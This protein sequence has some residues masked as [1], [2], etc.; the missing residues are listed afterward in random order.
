VS[1]G[2]R[3]G[4]ARLKERR[5]REHRLRQAE[6]DLAFALV[7]LQ[8]GRVAKAMLNVGIA[9]IRI[10]GVMSESEFDEAIAVVQAVKETADG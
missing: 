5:Y 9:S 4:H 10:G 1:D 2:H 7:A 6:K 8:E 3:E